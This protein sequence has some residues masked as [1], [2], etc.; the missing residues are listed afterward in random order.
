VGGSSLS[1]RRSEVVEGSRGDG[2]E[3][4]VYYTVY[5][6]ALPFLGADK[7]Q[8]RRNDSASDRE[9]RRPLVWLER[10]ESRL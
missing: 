8:N 1:V 2:S 7:G 9:M 3:A 4:G 10:R 6:E 5:G